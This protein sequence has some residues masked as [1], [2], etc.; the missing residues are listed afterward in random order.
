MQSAWTEGIA[1]FVA[2]GILTHGLRLCFAKRGILDIP[3]ARSSHSRPV[4]RGGGL[5]IVL[6]FLPAVIILWL[7]GILAS[8]TA[9]AIAGGGLLIAGVGLADDLRSLPVWLKGGAHVVASC[10]AVWCVGGMGPLDLGWTKWQWGWLGEAVAILGLVWMTNLYNF[11]D[12]IDALSGLEAVTAGA[13]GS[14]L[15]ARQGCSEF[16]ELGLILAS[17]C[18]GF[19]I[20]NWPPAKIF[21]GDV[22]SGFLG[23]VF[24]VLMITSAKHRPALIWTWL[25]LMGVFI[26][27]ATVTLARRVIRGDCWYAAHRSHAYQRA[28]RVWQS[29]AKVALGVGMVN[30]IWLFPFA[31]WATAAPGIAMPLAAAALLPLVWIAFHLGAG[32]PDSVNENDA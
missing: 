1:V 21:M 15:L 6:T 4:P 27:D 14:L 16:A 24:G 23:F 13:L 18:G 29:H 19:L 3:N 10:W 12:G 11:M 26:V 22:G 25:I 20:W 9:A 17:A 31:W 7:R 2:A 28:N 5:S 30:L 8:G 32:E